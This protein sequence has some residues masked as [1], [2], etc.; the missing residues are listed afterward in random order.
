MQQ[1]TCSIVRAA[2]LALAC[3][4][5][6][7]CGEMMGDEMGMDVGAEA[8]PGQ[9][10][11]QRESALV[12]GLN[13][14][15]DFDDGDVSD[16]RP[17]TGGGATLESRLSSSRAR[18]GSTSLKMTYAI[19]AGG[20]A[21]V[22]RTTSSGWNW[23]GG[24]ALTLSISGLATSHRLIVQLYDAGGERWETSVVVDFSGWRDLSLPLS[25][26]R[27]ATWQ[28]A[29]AQRNGVLDVAGIRGIALIPASSGQSGSIYLDSLR[30]NAST[31]T[32][33][34]QSTRPTG[35]IVPLYTYPTHSSWPAVIAVKKKY[36]AVPMIAVVNP[37]NGPGTSV[38][39]TYASGIKTLHAAGIQ[40]A[41]YVAT[42]Y[43][44][45]SST[46]VK[47][48]IQR[49][50]AFYPEVSAIF[51]DEQSA[52]VGY[53]SKYQEWTAYARG[54]GLPFTIGNPGG[55]SK[56]SYIGSVDT[57]LIYE[58]SG[59]P[60]LSRLTGWHAEHP[61]H[62]FGV[63]PYGVPSLDAAFMAQAEP[64]VGYIYVQNDQ[65]PNPWDSLPA[66]FESMVAALD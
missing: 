62:N 47:A 17:F 50:R 61:R 60:P 7:S 9:V 35:T 59:L 41:G 65:L 30:L 45:R 1:G 24:T 43:G 33:A 49:W 12:A 2:G 25:S 16:W 27:A 36:P 66:Y 19:P 40:V 38:S 18:S 23:T 37:N 20:Y 10:L 26:F 52:V 14:V 29:S 54:L 15:D 13:V 39:A 57:M 5:A 34:P 3:V 56:P 22:E 53:E 28:P 64:Y 4:A 6:V 32:G 8:E 31:S 21:G 11:E 44:A 42:T 46:D 58:S 48:E 63:I 55:D 51:F